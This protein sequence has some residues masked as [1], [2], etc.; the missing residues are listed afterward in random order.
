[1]NF[2]IAKAIRIPNHKFDTPI[3]MSMKLAQ[4][5]SSTGAKYV[6]VSHVSPTVDKVSLLNAL[7][8]GDVLTIT[9]S[10]SD[11]EGQTEQVIVERAYYDSA[12]ALSKHPCIKLLNCVEDISV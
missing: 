6:A 12:S 1:M 8:R 9:S 3:Y 7:N 4:T 2:E 11:Y 10:H 5:I